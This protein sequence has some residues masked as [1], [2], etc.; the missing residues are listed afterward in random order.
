MTDTASVLS[1]PRLTV[2]KQA[3]EGFLSSVTQKAQAMKYRLA[4]KVDSVPVLKKAAGKIK[5]F[6]ED[7]TKKYGKP[8]KRARNIILGV[9]MAYAAA[10]VGA[11]VPVP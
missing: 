6:D 5:A 8:Y 3:V 7:M 9:G 4:Q 1:T 11:S 2:S 10:K